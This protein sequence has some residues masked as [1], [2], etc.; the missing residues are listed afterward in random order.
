M[1]YSMLD[2]PMST[3]LLETAMLAHILRAPL[4][5]SR[6]AHQLL[7]Q[8]KLTNFNIDTWQGQTLI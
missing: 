2:K 1:R 6:G 8:V 4:G 5:D 7:Q 3:H